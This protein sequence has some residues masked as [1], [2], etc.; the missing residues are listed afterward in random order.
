MPPSPSSGVDWTMV[1]LMAP[2]PGVRPNFISPVTLE[3]EILAIGT[4]SSA[5][6]VTFLCMRLYSTLKITR[7]AWYDDVATV[8]ATVFSLTS[9]GLVIHARDCARHGWDLPVSAITAGFNKTTLAAAITSALGIAFS[10]VSILLLLYRLFHPNKALR[11]SLFGCLLWAILVSGTSIAVS[12][13]LCVARPGESFGSLQVPLR[14]SHQSIWAVIQGSLNVILDVLILCLPV[15]IICKLRL[16][17]R[18]KVGILAIFTT[19]FM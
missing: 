18:K 10:K 3:K 6:A 9:V 2:P 11:Y 5:L 7:S 15:P 13:A 16:G 4:V 19:G 14:C 8:L 1:P 12:L 17:K